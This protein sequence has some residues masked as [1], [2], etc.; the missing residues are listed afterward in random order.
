MYQ[1]CIYR[2]NGRD[3]SF[4]HEDLDVAFEYAFT[5]RGSEGVHDVEIVIMRNGAVVR[6]DPPEESDDR[7][8]ECIFHPNG[9]VTYFP[10]TEGGARPDEALRM[11]MPRTT[12]DDDKLRT[13]AD[14][15]PA[16]KRMVVLTGAG[17]ST[18]SGLPDYRGAEGLWKNRR[19]E[20]LADIET[21]RREP[22]EFWEF[23]RQRLA[24]LDGAQPNPGHLALAALERAGLVER[25]ITQ[26]ID[27]LHTAAGSKDVL[28]VHGS[29]RESICLACGARYPP[30]ETEQRADAAADGVPR[31]DCGPVL[32]PGRRPLWRN[33]PTGHQRRR[34]ARLPL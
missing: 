14:L 24:V 33:A 29:L 32:K 26:N 13:L 12:I 19:F 17:M 2:T 9:E 3:E 4:V 23:Y 25:V 10:R 34:G 30:T 6:F 28:E 20:E 15:I 31:C 21:F 18:E 11:P 22:V 1:V 8:I 27:G 16:S 5:M 7:P